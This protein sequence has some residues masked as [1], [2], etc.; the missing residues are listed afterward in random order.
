MHVD[1]VTFDIYNTV[2]ASN[3][4]FALTKAM[5]F[6]AAHRIMLLF[7]HWDYIARG[8]SSKCTTDLLHS[9]AGCYHEMILGLFPGYGCWQHFEEFNELIWIELANYSK[10]FVWT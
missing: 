7:S 1:G 2:I 8:C 10:F 3:K 4:S 9:V 6:C 5:S